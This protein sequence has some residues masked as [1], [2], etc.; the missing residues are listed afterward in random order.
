VSVEQPGYS[1]GDGTLRL[2]ATIGLPD[3]AAAPRAWLV[4]AQGA[5]EI[6][7][8][9]TILR[10]GDGATLTASAVLD[11]R[12]AGD[13]RPLEDGPWELLLRL[14][15]QGR[16]E[17]VPLPAGPARSAVL[18]GRPYVVRG[19]DAVLQLD[20]GATRSS[21]IGPVPQSRASVAESARGTLVTFDYP[22]LHVAGDAVLGARLL[23]GG[24]G[25]PARL[26][27][28]DGRARLEAYASSLAGTSPLSVV[29]GGGRPVATGLELR[30]DG[31][32]GM[33]LAPAAPAGTG[34]GGG[35]SLAQRL[36]RRTP[37]ALEPAVQRLSR[38]PVLRDAYRRLISR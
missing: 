34:S 3:P 18:D 8:P 2:T 6:A 21:V 15:W 7:L 20:A 12:S 37:H 32:G 5:A 10:E 16:E 4:V 26:I 11:P 27:C 23:L 31:A 29:A 36:R 14:A 35:T 33:T 22:S 30:V 19:A 28:R 17:T 13:G 24:F 1:W 25:L 38:V 9:A